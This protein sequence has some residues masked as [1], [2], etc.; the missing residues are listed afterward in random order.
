LRGGGAKTGAGHCAAS[1]FSAGNTTDA[2]TGAGWHA[3]RRRFVAKVGRPSG[4]V[5]PAPVAGYESG[6]FTFNEPR[7]M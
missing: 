4:V 6:T 3:A 1:G 2:E 7:K 5:A